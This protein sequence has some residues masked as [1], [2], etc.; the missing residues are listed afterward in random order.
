MR[1]FGFG[2][3]GGFAAFTLLIPQTVFAWEA[4]TH[5]G[6]TKWL[7]YKA[8]FS[9]VDAE[10]IASG[11]E[12]ADETSALAAAPIVTLQV[13]S[14]G[15][16]EASRHV[17]HHH[18]PFPGFIPSRPEARRV[19][20]SSATTENVANRWV[21]QEIK[22]KAHNISRKARLYRFG[23]SLH[24]L[25]DSWSHEGVPDVRFCPFRKKLFWAHPKERGGTLSHDPDLTYKTFNKSDSNVER[26][27]DMAETV[28]HFMKLFLDGNKE[29]IRPRNPGPQLWAG[30]RG[31]KE[32]VKSFAMLDRADK[33]HY[34]FKTELPYD[35]FTS[36]PCFLRGINLPGNSSVPCARGEKPKRP[37]VTTA[38]PLTGGREDFPE[39]LQDFVN[40]FLFDW[41]VRKNIVGIVERSVSFVDVAKRLAGN[42]PA[43]LRL[44]DAAPFD[45]TK[46]LFNMWLMRD[47]GEVTLLGHGM[48]EK[49][50]YNELKNKVLNITDWNPQTLGEVIHVLGADFPYL[51][52]RLPIE[53]E[54]SDTFAAVFQFR[55]ADRDTLIL[56]TRRVKGRWKVIEFY[57]IVI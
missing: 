14:G 20:R 39:G 1:F 17:Q 51:L 23:A 3:V 9:L 43:R 27:V 30:H 45:W 49:E 11:A 53:A 32:K 18:F 16:E 2:A 21:R 52:L 44:A 55:H 19:L 33:K 22:V 12:S 47:H 46:V 54:K 10:M 6:L 8:G 24:P 13:C 26:T 31:L 41:I 5:Y 48:P 50:G 38:S 37:K 40:S 15:S 35:S 42:E 29:F 28:Y 34:W 4:D 36:Y 25:A 7:A 56:K 57:W